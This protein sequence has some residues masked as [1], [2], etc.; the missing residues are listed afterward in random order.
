[1]SSKSEMNNSPFHE[2]SLY[3]AN[4]RN[5]IADAALKRQNY[6]YFLEYPIDYNYI[7]CLNIISYQ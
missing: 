7:L 4:R 2:N 6:D 3:D 1:M 5:N